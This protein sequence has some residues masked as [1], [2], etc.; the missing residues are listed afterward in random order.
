[1]SLVSA[2][3]ASALVGTLL[4]AGPRGSQTARALSISFE[5]ADSSPL[6]S[7]AA[8]SDALLDLGNVSAHT[9]VH[10]SRAILVRRALVVRVH[11]DTGVHGSAKVWANLR[12]DD[13]RVRV[14]L[15]GRILST[16][17]HL[18]ST[19]APVG[20]PVTHNLEI[21]VPTTAAPGALDAT[22][23]WSVETF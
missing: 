8:S 16:S 21:E 18:V 15:D 19:S 14:R 10:R 5:S 13:P 2:L 9:E 7:S 22:I 6:L 4:H 12:T 3:M 1:M 23:D 17:P 11:S 20:R